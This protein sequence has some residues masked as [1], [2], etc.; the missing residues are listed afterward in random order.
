MLGQ[1][2]SS[3][4]RSTADLRKGVKHLSFSTGLQLRSGGQLDLMPSRTK[5]VQVLHAKP[6]GP[7]LTIVEVGVNTSLSELLQRKTTAPTL[8]FLREFAL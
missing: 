4:E 3:F 5:K 7:T 6:S 1:S 2:S 8:G